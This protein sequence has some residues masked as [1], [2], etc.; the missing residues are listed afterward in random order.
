MSIFIHLS[1]Y[2]S[3]QKVG[4]LCQPSECSSSAFLE[5]L[6]RSHFIDFLYSGAN[7]PPQMD[8]Y[9]QMDDKKISKS[10]Y[11]FLFILAVLIP[12]RD[13]PINIG[14]TNTSFL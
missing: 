6:P 14:A 10:V 11:P 5:C 13:Y 4:K 9:K 8:I 1:L 7:L 2:R 12:R 3:A